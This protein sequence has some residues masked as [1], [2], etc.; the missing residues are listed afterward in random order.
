M[1]QCHDGW[2]GF[3]NLWWGGQGGERSED[4][5]L[6]T[7]TQ[8]GNQLPQEMSVAGPGKEGYSPLVG[9]HFYCN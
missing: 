1:G 3:S 5:K 9:R 6:R 2:K 8:S 4:R 7:K